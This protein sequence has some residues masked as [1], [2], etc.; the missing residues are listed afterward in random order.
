MCLAGVLMNTVSLWIFTRRAFR[1]RS[2]NI[3]LAGLS[4]SDVCLCFLAI[5]VFSL[6]Q[7]QKVIPG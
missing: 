7:L 3:L 2:I 4:A 1:K 6:N 5:P